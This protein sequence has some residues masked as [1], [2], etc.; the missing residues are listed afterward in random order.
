MTDRTAF[1]SQCDK[2]SAELDK[3]SD[4]EKEFYLYCLLPWLADRLE[5]DANVMNPTN[6]YEYLGRDAVR[7]IVSILRVVRESLVHDL[8]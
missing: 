3:L 6:G 1:E 5:A 2:I 4:W 7:R 8:F